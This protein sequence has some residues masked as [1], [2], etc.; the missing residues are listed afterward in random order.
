ML[1]VDPWHWLEEDGGLPADPRLRRRVL[2]ALR[3]VEY[4]SDLPPDGQRDTLIECKRRREGR[5]CRGLLVVELTVDDALFAF[6]PECGA[7]V[8][9]VHNWRG[10]RW[11]RSSRVLP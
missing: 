9:L 11:S 6:C 2:A 1:I 8:M 3:V 7:D 4:G 5:S 10:T